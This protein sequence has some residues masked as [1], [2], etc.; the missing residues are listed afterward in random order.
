MRCH[1][2]GQEIYA[3][4]WQAPWALTRYRQA[5][6]SDTG[7]SRCCLPSRVVPIAV[8]KAALC[9]KKNEMPRRLS[10]PG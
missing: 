10:A 6:R 8:L 2:G 1:T 4:D 5:R 9:L 7:Y 3:L